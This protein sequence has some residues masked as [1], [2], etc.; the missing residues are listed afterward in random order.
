MIW[1]NREGLRVKVGF[2][3]LG[4]GELGQ[5]NRREKVVHTSD[6]PWTDRGAGKWGIHLQK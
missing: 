6:F 1:G 5:N 2:R 3:I 4:K